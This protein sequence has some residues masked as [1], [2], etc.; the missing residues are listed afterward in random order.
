MLR[1]LRIILSSVVFWFSANMLATVAILYV[2]FAT[3]HLAGEVG[4]DVFNV[5]F[6]LLSGGLISF[7]FYFLVVFIPERRRARLLKENMLSVYRNIRR[8]VVISVVIAS[9]KGGRSDLSTAYDEMTKLTDVRHFK[10]YFSE[11]RE[12]D[13]GFYAFENQMG[14]RTYEFDRILQDIKLLASQLSFFLNNY[15][16][17]KGEEFSVIKRFEIH[18]LALADAQPGYEESKPLCGFIYQWLAGW[19]PISGYRSHDLIQT[20]LEEL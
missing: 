1:A 16:T 5:L 14:D 13:E 3:T 17:N 7:L 20:T 9:T 11:G 4:T 2:R 8:D 19:D 15:A 18:L 10:E 6:N 12:A